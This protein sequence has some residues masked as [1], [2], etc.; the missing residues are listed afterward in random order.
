[1]LIKK[2]PAANDVV[3]FKLV[4]GEEIVGKIVNTTAEV[5]TVA[6]PVV[7]QLHG[8]QGGQAGIGFAPYS[9]AADDAGEFSYYRSQVL[10][11]PVLARSDIA[12]AYLK[13]TTGLEIAEGSL[14]G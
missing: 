1:M 6:K 8:L 12:A 2:Q 3:A 11:S 5:I 9:L 14:L 4:N 13:A 10:A 7:V